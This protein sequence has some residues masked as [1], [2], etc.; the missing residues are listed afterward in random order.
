MFDNT[1][2]T[3]KICWNK[4]TREY[5]MLEYLQPNYH[6]I[7]NIFPNRGLVLQINY[8][9]SVYCGRKENTVSFFFFS[10]FCANM[11]LCF[12]PWFRFFAQLLYISMPTCGI[13]DF[14][15]TSICP[16]I[17][18]T[19]GFFHVN[20]CFWCVCR[21]DQWDPFLL[22]HHIVLYPHPK[23]SEPFWAV[24]IIFTDVQSYGDRIIRPFKVYTATNTRWLIGSVCNQADLAQ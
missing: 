9:K 16:A 11:Q 24:F 19:A 22:D 3:S 2:D 13:L 8:I 20:N 10:F 18:L 15:K 17:F 4:L 6:K 5:S 14:L 12:F 23:S 7:N 21:Q 1:S